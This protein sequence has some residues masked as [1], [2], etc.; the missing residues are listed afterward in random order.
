MDAI[1]PE[2]LEKAVYWITEREAIRRAKEA[3]LPKPWSNDPLFLDW[4]WCN[5]RRLDDAVS[6][7]LMR[8]WY[9]DA[10]ARTQLVAATLGRLINWPEALL[11]ASRGNPFSLELL[12][13]IRA[14]L[15]MRAARGLKTFTG[16]YVVAGHPGKSKI[17]SVCDVATQVGTESSSIASSSLRETW[18]KLTSVPLLGSFLSGQ[19]VA[20]IAHLSSGTRWPDRWSWA[21]VGPGSA[22]GMN[23]L[24]GRS[25][26]MPLRQR[27]FDDELADYIEQ[28]TPHI[29]LIAVDRR[30]CAQDFQSTLCELDKR[31]RLELREGTVRATYPGRASA[32]KSAQSEL[33]A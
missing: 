7:I 18:T 21:P 23:R 4:R 28:I 27:Q 33:F 15:H 24:R 3:G 29:E 30:L 2:M 12:P 26:K 5:V 9:C 19:I 22:R 20:D 8:E 31:C 1:L 13:E 32:P 6:V 11:D 16:A 17:D 14:R 25:F 10:D